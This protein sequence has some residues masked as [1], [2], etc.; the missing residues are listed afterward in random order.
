MRS[1]KFFTA[2]IITQHKRK[3]KSNSSAV[4][5]FFVYAHYIARSTL[6]LRRQRVQT[7]IRLG[8][9]LTITRTFCVFG[10]QVRRVLRLEWLTLL[11]KTTPL[12][13][14]SQYFPI[15]YHTSFKDMSLQ[16][17]LLYHR[18]RQKASFFVVKNSVILFF[19]RGIV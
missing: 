4:A 12:P 14:T 1:S 11:P 2:H 9:P 10:A 15:F 18:K 17:C 8:A 13:H 16:T 6:L 19:F 7:D 5:L 3:E